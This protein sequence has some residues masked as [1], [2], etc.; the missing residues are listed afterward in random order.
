MSGSA[1]WAA[2]G[3]VNLIG[4]HT[5]YNDGFVLPIALPYVTTATVAP[6]GGGRLLLRSAQR[7]G[8]AVETAVADLRPGALDG[9]AAYA[10]GVV[11]ALAEAGHAVGGGWEVAVDGRVPEGAGLSSS[12]ALECSV[13]AALD[14]A[15]GLGLSRP[16][17]ARLAQRA[18][19]G[20]V[21]MP[22][23]AMDQMASM[24]CRAG[25][26]LFLD[27]RSMRAEHV[28][29]DVAAE[30]LGILVVD[31]RAPHRLVG[32]EYADRRRACE[33]AAAA[34]GVPA[35]RDVPLDGLDA[36]LARLDDDVR[37][38]R[39]RHVVTENDRVLRTVDLLRA[40][41]T[42]DVGPL[43]TASH[44][45][46][47]DDFEVTVPQLDVAVDAALAAGALGARMTGGGFGGCVLALVE[48]GAEAAVRAAVDSAYAGRGF[49][50]PAYFLAAPSDGA[51]RVT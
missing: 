33:A 1:T 42:R 14:D 22:S 16:E 45:S 30:G 4:E 17:L 46:L 32:G 43:L 47:R 35:L 31:T 23:G 2:P 39:V 24:L 37:R 26:A 9:W 20:F 13:A 27:T 11:W 5:D 8:E 49:T 19:N 6:A 10:A 25:A 40:G 41:R 12:A 21:G 3:R 36:A 18:E 51:R 29:L 7:P 48:T 38:R 50:A 15:L 28:P 44:A 34:L